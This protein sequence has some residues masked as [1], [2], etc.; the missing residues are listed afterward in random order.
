VKCIRNEEYSKD[1]EQ[2][3]EWQTEVSVNLEIKCH[4]RRGFG[5]VGQI[6]PRMNRGR[7]VI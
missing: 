5:D 4:P 1:E 2:K 6:H 7:F 3:G